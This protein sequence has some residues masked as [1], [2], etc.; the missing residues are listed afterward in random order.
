MNTFISSYQK[1]GNNALVIDLE[2]WYNSEFLTDHL[3]DEK[4]SQI[5]ESVFP[6]LELLD[7]YN[8]R[9]TFAVLGVVAERYAELVK[10]IFDQGHEIASHGYSH[11]TLYELS[12]EEFE[13][14]IAKSVAILTA[15]TGERP[16]GFRAPCFSLNNSNRWVLQILQRHGFKYDASV[17]PI[18]IHFYGVPKAPLY[19]YKPSTEDITKE[20]KDG[21]IVEF[22]MTVFRLG[23]NIPVAGGFYKN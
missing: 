17:F 1:G 3:P 5:P 23:V 11:K 18:R 16:I 8:T 12:R 9:A 4:D 14:E 22:P 21:N 13:Q 20:S 10:L 19:P 6:L 15:I 7:K 2:F